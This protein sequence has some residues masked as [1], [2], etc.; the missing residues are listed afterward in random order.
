MGLSNEEKSRI[1]SWIKSNQETLVSSRKAQKKLSLDKHKEE[2]KYLLYEK[3][4]GNKDIVS[5]LQEQGVDVD[6]SY[7]ST[8]RRRYLNIN[9]SKKRV[10]HNNKVEKSQQHEAHK[11]DEEKEDTDFAKSTIFKSLQTMK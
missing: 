5:Y 8:Y 1:D 11:E 10:T 7:F 2:I 3:R 4:L 9:K 6:D